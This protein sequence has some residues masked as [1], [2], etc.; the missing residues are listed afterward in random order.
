MIEVKA[1]EKRT[2]ERLAKERKTMPSTYKNII[3]RFVKKPGESK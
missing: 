2:K 1:V 3:R